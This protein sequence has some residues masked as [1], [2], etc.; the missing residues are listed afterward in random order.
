MNIAYQIPL[1]GLDVHGHL[2]DGRLALGVDRIR[3]KLLQ[4]DAARP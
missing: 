4:V 2:L 1:A 3:P